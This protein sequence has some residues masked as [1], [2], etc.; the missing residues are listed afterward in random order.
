MGKPIHLLDR[1]AFDRGLGVGS[2]RLRLAICD[3]PAYSMAINT[4]ESLPKRPGTEALLG[5]HFLFLEGPKGRRVA[6]A[7]P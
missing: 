2:M 3:E 4:D 6:S 7:P 1:R 5:L